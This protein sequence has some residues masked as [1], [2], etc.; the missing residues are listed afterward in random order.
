MSARRVGLGHFLLTALVLVAAVSARP[1]LAAPPRQIV[2]PGD[3]ATPTP[4]YEIILIPTATPA[5]APLPTRDAAPVVDGPAVEVAATYTV[6]PGDTLLTVALEVGLDVDEMPC[7]VA[8][9]FQP[10]QP[11]VIGNVL[12]LPDLGWRCHRVE[13][14]E[15]LGAV[16]AAY[17]ID[18]AA[19][20]AVAWNQLA[21]TTAADAVLRPG[22]YL[23]IPPVLTD[24]AGGFLGYMLEQPVGVS[25]L[26]AYA[27]GGPRAKPAAVGPLP[28]NW[29]YGSGVF[30]WPVFGWLSQGYRDD[31]RALDIAAQTG[32]F[33]TAADRGVVVRAGWNDQGYGLFVVVDHNID[34]ITLYAHLNEVYVREGDV[35]GQGQILGTVGSTGNSTGPHLHFEIR[36]FGSRTN[37]LALL[38]R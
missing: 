8:P 3:V 24:V 12:T 9:A 29:P 4:T 35:V 25:P 6:E 19:I 15:T 32:A 13:A 11:L 37:P 31:H 5:V 27:V 14:G 38:A 34:Y 36:D 7:A 28:E 22:H 33:V 17:G 16:A 2:Q 10:D 23:R 30:T 20:T 26:T 21:S 1:G 18:K